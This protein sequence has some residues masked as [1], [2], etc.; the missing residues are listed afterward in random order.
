MVRRKEGQLATPESQSTGGRRIV[1]RP[2]V[3]PAQLGAHGPEIAPQSG[4][5]RQ[6]LVRVVDAPGQ[7]QAL[8]QGDELVHR[9][10][11]VGGVAQRL[12]ADDRPAGVSHHDDRAAA[13]GSQAA[14]RVGQT[15][16]D[17]GRLDVVVGDVRQPSE[18]ARE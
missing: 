16:T 8:A 11:V 6:A 1:C 12:E 17:I 15:T 10:V 2:E 5:R 18:P 14:D 4:G 7:A 13:L 9:I 3:G